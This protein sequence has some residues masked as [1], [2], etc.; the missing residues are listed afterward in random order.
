MNFS[1]WFDVPENMNYLNIN[2]FSFHVPYPRELKDEGKGKEKKQPHG[3]TVCAA[4]FIAK[5]YLVLKWFLV[6]TVNSGKVS[7]TFTAFHAEYENSLVSRKDN[8]L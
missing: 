4:Y 5:F 3:K 8:N 6:G 1:T 7:F 2:P